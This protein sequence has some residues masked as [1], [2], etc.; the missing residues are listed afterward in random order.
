MK[1]FLVHAAMLSVLTATATHASAYSGD[2]A[3]VLPK[4][5]IADGE[6]AAGARGV[7]LASSIASTLLFVPDANQSSLIV[8]VGEGGEGRRG[9]RWRDRGHR[10]NPYIGRPY[11]YRQNYRSW[12]REPTYRVERPSYGP[13]Y[14]Y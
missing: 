6:V 14:R 12:N 2:M 4:P 7:R 13:S 5:A 10:H 3:L 1:G 8:Q 11:Q 9:R